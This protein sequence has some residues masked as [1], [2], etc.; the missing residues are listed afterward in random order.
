MHVL[1]ASMQQIYAPARI[2]EGS[3]C[4]KG[5]SPQRGHLTYFLYTTR[6]GNPSRRIKEETWAGEGEGRA[7]A[8][9]PPPFIL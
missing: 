4:M 6:C 3:L 9:A 2:K 7:Q 1:H 8:G 5:T